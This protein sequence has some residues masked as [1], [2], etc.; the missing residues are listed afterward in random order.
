MLDKETVRQQEALGVIGVN[1]IHGTFYGRAPEAIIGSLLDNLT[2]ERVEVDMIRFAGPAF[3]RVDNRLMALQL[4]KEGLTEAAMF[5]AQGEAIQWSEGSLQE[6]RSG[7]AWEFQA[8]H[9]AS[10]DV[11]ERGL[12]TFLQE[13][14]LKGEQPVVL[15][16]MTLRHLDDRRWDRCHGLFCSEPKPSEPLAKTVLVS[17]FRTI[18][19]ARLLPFAL[20]QPAAG[21]GAWVL[22]V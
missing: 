11:L 17:N 2:W 7:P 3:P 14:E 20:H 8:C 21:L 13:P 18:S 9:K 4:V 15:M 1:L 22:P 12:E 19:S 5:T 6:T 16:E 10:L